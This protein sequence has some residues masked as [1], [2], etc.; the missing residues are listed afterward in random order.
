MGDCG[1]EIQP[2][3]N[4]SVA[5]H[6]TGVGVHSGTPVNLTLGPADINAGFIFVRTGLDGADREVRATATAV[7]ATDFAT[8]LGDAIG[9]AGVH[10]RTCA[11][12]AARH[13]RR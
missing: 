9:P 8:V 6:V 11:G 7:T 12:R 3:D 1:D 2:A 5:R 4:A 13:G 10:R